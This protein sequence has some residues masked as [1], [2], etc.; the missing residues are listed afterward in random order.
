ME[1]LAARL[2]WL[3]EQK[4]YSQK[5]IAKQISMTLNGYQKL[6]YDDRDPKLD[7]LVK[8]AD[9]YDVT[10][11]FL[12]G[13]NNR[14]KDLEIVSYRLQELDMII[15]M[16]NKD[17]NHMVIVISELRADM[18]ETSRKEGLT[19]QSTIK[20]SHQLDNMLSR[21]TIVQTEIQELKNKYC[22][23][24]YDYFVTILDIPFSNI[25][26]DKLFKKFLPME[27][28]VQQDLFEEYSLLL[29]G[30]NVGSFGYYGN[31]KT[32]EEAEKAKAELIAR[33]N[34]Q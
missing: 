10:T 16:K 29:Y 31:Y 8:L 27:I 30:N 7:V 25:K 6:E 28:S 19:S 14:V 21:H 15:D 22:E 4:R 11:D 23:A 20:I 32:E 3:R 5:D 34:G 18:I 2:K 9:L 24:V 1:I 26:N 12:L 33:I 13:R 17:L